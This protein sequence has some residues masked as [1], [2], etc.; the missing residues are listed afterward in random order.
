[1]IYK[2]FKYLSLL[3]LGLIL[4]L[5]VGLEGLYFYGLK[6][7]PENRTPTDKVYSQTYHQLLWAQLEGTKTIQVKPISAVG[8]SISLLDITIF[9]DDLIGRQSFPAG[10]I[11]T[12]L[13]SRLLHFQ[14]PTRQKASQWHYANIVTAIWLSKH[15]T[16][17]ETLNTLLSQSYFGNDCY[18]VEAAAMA[19]FE[20]AHETL[21]TN[22]AAL[23][24]GILKAPSYYNPWTNHERALTVM[25]IV[26][27]KLTIL[28]PEEYA[29]L[30]KAEELPTSLVSLKPNGCKK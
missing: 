24:I 26:I 6:N 25:N 10:T 12:G 22:E 15:W 7:L 27:E 4:I 19:Y 29:H 21:N 23:L 30:Q 11:T 28:W 17:D 13:T 2:F 14:T 8:V 3:F 20:K 1:M 9:N 5:V 18:G 16:T